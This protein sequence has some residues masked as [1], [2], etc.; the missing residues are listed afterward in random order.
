MNWQSDW[1]LLKMDQPIRWPLVSQ[2]SFLS[3]LPSDW[4]LLELNQPIGT[5]LLWFPSTWLGFY[6]QQNCVHSR[7][8]LPPSYSTRRRYHHVATHRAC[9]ACSA[10]HL[11]YG[12]SESHPAGRTWSPDWFPAG[13]TQPLPSTHW[14]GFWVSNLCLWKVANIPVR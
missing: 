1:L 8:K 10:G 5:C 9:S 14:P 4:L 13:T 6:Q 12:S 7:P 2:R 11:P 3:E